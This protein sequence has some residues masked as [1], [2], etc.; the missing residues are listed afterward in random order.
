MRSNFLYNH[1][2]SLKVHSFIRNVF[3]GF[4]AIISCLGILKQLVLWYCIKLRNTR[5]DSRYTWMNL[6]KEL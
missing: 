2:Q 4:L 1:A 5:A 6:F 3:M